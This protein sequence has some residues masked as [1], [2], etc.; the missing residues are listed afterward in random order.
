MTAKDGLGQTQ[1]VIKGYVNIT[2][3]KTS[4]T[5]VSWQTTPVGE[6]IEELIKSKL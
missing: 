1:A 4:Y 5:T 6:V 2:G 3:A